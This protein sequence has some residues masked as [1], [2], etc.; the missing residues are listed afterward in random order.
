LGCMRRREDKDQRSPP[1]IAAPGGSGPS[2][3]CAARSS[4]VTA[5]RHIRRRH[6]HVVEH[7]RVGESARPRPAPARSPGWSSPRS[8]RAAQ[9]L[10]I[11]LARTMGSISSLSFRSPNWPGLPSPRAYWL[12]R[13]AHF[14]HS[15]DCVCNS[16]LQFPDLYRKPLCICCSQSAVLVGF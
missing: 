11:Q 4:R 5:H 8:Q 14:N 3:D 7:P 2:A 16:S 6:H 1:R 9:L 15:F 12:E 13:S 10:L